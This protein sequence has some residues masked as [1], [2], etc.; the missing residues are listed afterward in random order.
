MNLA[1]HDPSHTALR[2]AARTA[3]VMPA[4]FG[5]T[6]VAFDNTQ[7]SLF[8]AFGSFSML[9]FADFGGPPRARLVAYLL[10]TACGAVLI[11]LGTVL[12][13]NAWIAAAGMAVVA[14][15]IVFGGV[16]GGYVA[17]GGLAASLSFVLAVAVHDDAA[18]IPS[19]IAGW[20]LA[21]AACTVAA[22]FLWP[23][24]E[25]S[26]LKR[27][28]EEAIDAAVALVDATLTPG[29]SATA[30]ESLS[31]AS[32]EA[33][34]AMR[35]FYRSMPYRPAGPTA[36]DQAIAYLVEE[37]SWFHALALELVTDRDS[38]KP[39]D[40]RDASLGAATVSTL[41]DAA[42]G[43]GEPGVA[44]ESHALE[45]ERES[46]YESVAA[47]LAKGVV[48]GEDAGAI[49]RS[50]DRSFRLRMLS[51][52]TV[53]IAAN[54][55]ILGRQ[56]V[57][58]NAFEIPPLVPQGSLTGTVK[59]LW[60]ILQGH[61]RPD[62]VWFRAGL[63]AAIALGLAI[64][65]ADLARLDHAFWVVLGTMT[66]LK[67]NA[68]TTSFAAWQA[69]AGTLAGF[70][71]ATAALLAVGESETALWVLLPICVFLAVYTPTAIHVI[72]GQAMFTVT[73]VVLFNLIEPQGWRTGLIRVEDILIGCA[74]SIVVG[75]L[76]WP[77]GARGQLRSALSAL[78][79]AGGD[80]VKGA[81][82]DA[83]K[84]PPGEP[85]AALAA[86]ATTSGLRA[87]EAFS[88]Y[89]NERGPKT[90]SPQLWG[91]ILGF[92][93][94]LRFV[95]DAV[96]TRTRVYG[97][98]SGFDAAAAS[99]E[100]DLDGLHDEIQGAADAVRGKART[101]R[102]VLVGD[103][104]ETAGIVSACVGAC[105]RNPSRLQIEH[106]LGIAWAGNWI[107][108]V[109]HRLVSVDDQLEQVRAIGSRP[110]WR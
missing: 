82:D 66:V 102:A 108:H 56:R 43:L 13:G 1:A 9:A 64:L 38:G 55:A 53:S 67:S 48:D 33:M 98:V 35:R 23:R 39:F 41:R 93:E 31:R 84:W 99:I 42:S 71:L 62:S 107:E 17:A 91:G 20:G 58:P 88:T 4:L 86:A 45:A 81:I 73:V 40:E 76:L 15:A 29:V 51:Y 24:H 44:V 63:R 50:I 78:L 16:L 75:V 61:L 34:V 83:L 47:S 22:L 92:G 19:R 18:A 12:S 5:I 97:P 54:A 65:I 30:L 49:G 26:R 28:I 103:D 52:L 25:R 27:L 104:F 46:Y 14:F 106:L 85:V 94:H 8:A 80:Y 109:R 60:V 32:T 36:H 59:T 95:G 3:L 68:V 74:T 89:L 87:G 37:L 69:L 57:D 90:L 77:R 21:G 110:W 10:L 100:H 70:G 6:T 96:A 101:G 7:L 72:V 105:G 11:S 79:E 2:R